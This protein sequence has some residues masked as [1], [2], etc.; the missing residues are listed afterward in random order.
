MNKDTSPAPERFW[1]DM[2]RVLLMSS[3]ASVSLVVLF[4]YLSRMEQLES[5]QVGRWT[6]NV[7]ANSEFF[8]EQKG[9]I[10]FEINQWGRSH[11]PQRQFMRIGSERKPT[12]RFRLVKTPDD[13]IVAIVLKN[14]I[15]MIHEF[16]S[17]Y[18]WPGP[19][20][21]SEPQWQMAEL[22]LERLR[23]AAPEVSCPRQQEYRRQLDRERESK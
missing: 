18:T 23:A 7:Y 22:L 20:T 16:S 15:Q 11:I 13:E 12:Q 8:Y 1:R 9:G 21:V 6:I 10:Y 19:Y 17:G 5:F 3:L 2:L 14:E 4:A